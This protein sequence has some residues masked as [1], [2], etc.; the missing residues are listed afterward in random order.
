MMP[1]MAQPWVR[2]LAGLA[3]GGRTLLFRLVG[4]AEWALRRLRGR[5]HLP[6]L[7]LRRHTGPPRL[8]ESAA[9]VTAFLFAG[10]QA[11][12]PSFP[13]PRAT[14][15]AAPVR[16]RRA[17]HPRAAVAY[18]RGRFEGLVAEA[19]LTTEV[20]VRG[21]WPGADRPPTGQDTLVLGRPGGNPGSALP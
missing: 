16:W 12:P 19:D 6:P 7:W 13:H 15:S 10:D 17:A 2:R 5:D 21:F 8:F 14:G 20:F 18:D 1:D 3:R 9:L 11:S 4:P